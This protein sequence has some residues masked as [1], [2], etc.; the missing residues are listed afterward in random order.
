[1]EVTDQLGKV[2]ELVTEM[3]LF[4]ANYQ[5]I[6]PFYSHISVMRF[7][8]IER[9]THMERLCH[10]SQEP[11]YGVSDVSG[12]ASYEFRISASDQRSGN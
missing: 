3:G 11:Q 1:M 6:A 9:V 5:E 8:R 12:M 7:P 10:C 2:R 4:Q